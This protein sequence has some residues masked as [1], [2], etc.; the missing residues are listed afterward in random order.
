MTERTISVAHVRWLTTNEILKYDVV[1]SDM[2]FNGDSALT[3]PQKVRSYQRIKKKNA[4]DYS[5]VETPKSPSDFGCIVDV[6]ANIRKINPRNIT[7]FGAHARE[8]DQ[9]ISKLACPAKRVDNV[10]ESKLYNALNQNR[11]RT[12]TKDK[13]TSY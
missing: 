10:I 3:K 2:F 13:Y 4:T 11:F 8:F 12:S 6:M 5:F 1:Q 9:M 7:T